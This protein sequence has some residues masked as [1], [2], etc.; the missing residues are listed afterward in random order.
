MPAEAGIQLVGDNNNFKDLDSRFRGNDGAFPFAKQS[1]R[2]EGR[3]GVISF[4]CGSA[5]LFSL[6]QKL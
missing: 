4:A 3:E 6:W 1:L 2:G 5:S